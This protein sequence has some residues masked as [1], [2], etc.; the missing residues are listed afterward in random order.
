MVSFL[1]R[2][3]IPGLIIQ[4][5]TQRQPT[6]ILLLGKSHPSHHFWIASLKLFPK[7]AALIIWGLGCLR[8]SLVHFPTVSMAKNANLFVVVLG[9]VFAMVQPEFGFS[10]LV[11]MKPRLISLTGDQ[12]LQYTLLHSPPPLHPLS[13]TTHYSL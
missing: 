13:T 1:T 11:G 6:E 12:T 3:Y 5:V 8:I 9:I 2:G 7:A 10:S 4:L